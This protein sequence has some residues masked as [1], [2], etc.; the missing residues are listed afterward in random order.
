MLRLLA[1]LALIASGLPRIG[2]EVA[3][4]RSGCA[5][6]ACAQPAVESSGCCGSMSD[7]DICP[8]SNGPCSCFAAPIPEPQPKPQ[9][10]QPR[11]DR[12]SITG[13]PNGPPQIAVAV[14]RD[15]AWPLMSP[16]VIALTADKSHNELQAILGIW[17]T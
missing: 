15:D 16:L 2:G 13:L 4:D 14:E 10:P 11:P 8:M 6:L 3:S 7:A 12:E 5:E 17:R 9:T 1:I